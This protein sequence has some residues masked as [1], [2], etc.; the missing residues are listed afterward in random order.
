MRPIIKVWMTC[1]LLC[2]LL[3]SC[4]GDDQGQ[5]ANVGI[6]PAELIVPVCASCEPATIQGVVATGLPM[7]DAQVLVLDAEGKRQSTRTDQQGRYLI[8]VAG[9]NA[10]LLVQATGTILGE[11]QVLHTVVLPTEVGRALSNITPLTEVLTA[12]VLQ[13][14]PHELILQNQVD[15]RRINTSAVHAV[16]AELERLVRHV[17]DAAGVPSAV[18]LRATAFE[19]NHT[20]LDQALDWLVLSREQGAYRLRHVLNAPEDALTIDPTGLSSSEPLPKPTSLD[21]LRQTSHVATEIQARLDSLSTLFQQGLPDAATLAPFLSNSSQQENP[22]LR[23][24]SSDDGGFSYQ[25]AKWD[26]VRV[27]R[28]LNADLV[29]VQ[30]RLLPRLPFASRIET[31]WMVRGSDG[32]QWQG[33]DQLAQVAVRHAWVLGA[34]PDG[35]SQ[36][37]TSYL[38]FE[39]DRHFVAPLVAQVVVRGPGLP[40]DGLT[41]APPD[42]SLGY[43]NWSW[44]GHPNDDW[45]AVPVGWCPQDS[46]DAQ[47]VCQESWLQVRTGSTYTFE[48]LDASGQ[49]LQILSAHLPPRLVSDQSIATQPS[50]WF[51]RFDLNA[52]ALLTPSKGHIEAMSPSPYRGDM[53]FSLPWRASSVAVPLDAR[54]DVYRQDIADTDVEIPP[55]VIRIFRALQPDDLVS[56]AWPSSPTLDPVWATLRLTSS[57]Q[58]GNK[59]VHVLSPNNWQ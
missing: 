3:A 56:A 26:Q 59:Y 15:F 19:A 9:F 16:E 23:Q 44:A 25:G 17:L 41:L 32:W 49:V 6:L 34:G 8:N 53:S 51:S 55:Q 14:L 40:A 46:D 11:A 24:D 7:A 38:L 31:T 39:V 37:V 4:G 13:G 1:L 57:D 27:L 18:D 35:Y 22:W 20:G 21:T 47:L 2:L 36:H 33:N 5:R 42:D 29:Q 45:P 10:P 54:L 28:L 30:Y 50:A 58:W 48:L 12:Q 43:A 52:D